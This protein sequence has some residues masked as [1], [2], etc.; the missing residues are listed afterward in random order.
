MVYGSSANTE[1]GTAFKSRYG[2]LVDDWLM[3]TVCSAMIGGSV[4]IPEIRGKDVRY[5]ARYVFLEIFE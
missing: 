1:A 5:F 4:K 2:M 3:S